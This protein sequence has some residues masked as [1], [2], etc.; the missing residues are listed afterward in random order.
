MGKLYPTSSK[1]QVKLKYATREG[2]DLG[3]TFI[4]VVAGIEREWGSQSRCAAEEYVLHRFSDV[5]LQK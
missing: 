4:I 3:L 2:C 5:V 1:N